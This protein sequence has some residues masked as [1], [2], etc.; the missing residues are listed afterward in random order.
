MT[1]AW[2]YATSLKIPEELK[3][4]LD[5]LAASAHKTTPA[6]M[7][8]ILSQEAQRAELREGFA[9]K[10]VASENEAIENA[11]TISLDRTFDYLE[12]RISGGK[13]R[14]PQ[15]RPWKLRYG[16]KLI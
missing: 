10:A 9:A 6:S 3:R 7:V 14:R 13:S 1:A 2:A 8:D 5:R 16:R 15:P 12:K 11:T 4:R